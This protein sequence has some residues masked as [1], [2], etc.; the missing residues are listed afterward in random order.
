MQELAGLTFF[1]LTFAIVVR[2]VCSNLVQRLMSS[3]LY[4]QKITELMFY[5]I[6]FMLEP[7]KLLWVSMTDILN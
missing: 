4:S 6:A 5:N 1:R 3:V 2:F 7:I